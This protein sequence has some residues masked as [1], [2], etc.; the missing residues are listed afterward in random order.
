MLD[1]NTTIHPP[2]LCWRN[3]SEKIGIFEPGTYCCWHDSGVLPDEA[4][5]E[6]YRVNSCLGSWCTFICVSITVPTCMWSWYRKQV[7]AS[8]HCIASQHL[9][10]VY[11]RLRVVL[12]HQTYQSSQAVQGMTHTHTL[13]L[14]SDCSQQ[15]LAVNKLV[16]GYYVVYR[17]GHCN[18]I[19]MHVLQMWYICTR[20][21][22][23]VL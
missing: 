17:H 21:E 14:T 11:N 8:K 23:L 7:K 22:P 15:F 3:S 9:C 12:H 2:L 19:P 4:Y 18:T 20:T 6:K 1:H 10:V 5:R 16:W 13:L